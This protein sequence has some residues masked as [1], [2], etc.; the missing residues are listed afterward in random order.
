MT[1]GKRRTVLLAALEIDFNDNVRRLDGFG[2][3]NEA[4]P[5]KCN[6]IEQRPAAELDSVHRYHSLQ[7]SRSHLRDSRYDAR[8]SE[9]LD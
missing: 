6:S 3:L 1:T 8:W 4:A 9:N 5:L 2:L 7:S